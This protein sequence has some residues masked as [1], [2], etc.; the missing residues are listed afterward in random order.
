MSRRI[1][2]LEVLACHRVVSV[3][4][5]DRLYGV[6]PQV[7]TGLPRLT[8]TVSPVHMRQ[9]LVVDATFVALKERT[10]IRATPNA[11][12]HLAGTA[13]MQVALG[14]PLDR[15]QVLPSARKG[16]RPDAE[17][18]DPKGEGLTA[19]EYD[20]GS[21]SRRI[22]DQKLTSYW[23]DYDS[24]VWG[25]GSVLR[26]T[27]LQEIMSRVILVRWWASEKRNGRDA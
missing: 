9:S 20:S 3:R 16:N 10:L 23:P 7:L 2:A 21:Y 22:I 25:V 15:W 6:P 27:R 13:E 26:Q 19:V 11:L 14:I 4:Q 24:T 1:L 5:L 8:V 17:Y 18:R 12:A